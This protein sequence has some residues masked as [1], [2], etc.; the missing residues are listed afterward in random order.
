MSAH[1]FFCV[2]ITGGHVRQTWQET[3]SSTLST[4][5][6]HVEPRK[7]PPAGENKG[8]VPMCLLD[9]EHCLSML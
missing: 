9:I 8:V 5:A 1:V 2:K 4:S 7:H 3:F 6:G